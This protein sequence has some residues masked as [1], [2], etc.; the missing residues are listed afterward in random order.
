MR[1]NLFLLGSSTL[2]SD[3]SEPSSKIVQKSIIFVWKWWTFWILPNFSRI[4]RNLISI[5]ADQIIS[6]WH[7]QDVVIYRHTT[8]LSSGGWYSSWKIYICRGCTKRTF[9]ESYETLRCEI[10]LSLTWK[11]IHN[12]QDFKF[13]PFVAHIHAIIWKYDHLAY[14][15][16]IT[17]WCRNFEIFVKMPFKTPAHYKFNLTS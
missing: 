11:Y 13:R 16:V 15:N 5:K 9:K 10:K 3:L 12:F 4:S 2:K 1:F 14:D 8:M 17:W 7:R 6:C